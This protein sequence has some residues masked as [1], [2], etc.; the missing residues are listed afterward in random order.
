VEG[1]LAVR[2][3]GSR[4]V[5]TSLQGFLHRG[6]EGLPVELEDIR[7]PDFSPER[8]LF[9]LVRPEVDPPVEQSEAVV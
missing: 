6:P 4:P 5:A 3:S 8:S 9:G 1:E 7:V 2:V